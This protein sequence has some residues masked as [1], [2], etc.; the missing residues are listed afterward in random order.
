MASM[1]AYMREAAPTILPASRASA[2]ETHASTP[3]TT[4][5]VAVTTATEATPFRGKRTSTDLRP[6]PGAEGNIGAAA[7]P[8]ALIAAAAGDVQ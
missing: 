1:I 3:P 6:T 7:F 8:P 5:T 2:S 4:R